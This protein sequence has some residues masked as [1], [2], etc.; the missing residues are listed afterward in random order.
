MANFYLRIEG[1]PPHVP[2]P[3]VRP[4]RSETMEDAQDEATIMLRDD[5]S[6]ARDRERWGRDAGPLAVIQSADGRVVST[7]PTDAFNDAWKA[8]GE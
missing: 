4:L 1:L 3:P 6:W 2:S 8:S 5:T 7:R